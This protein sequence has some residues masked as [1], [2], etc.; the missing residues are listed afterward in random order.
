ASIHSDR[1]DDAQEEKTHCQGQ[2]EPGETTAPPTLSAH[3]GSSNYWCSVHHVSA[4]SQ[5]WPTIVVKRL[6]T[7]LQYTT[8][9]CAL[10]RW[11]TTC[12]ILPRIRL[13]K[14]STH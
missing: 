13:L 8:R 12:A 1:R 6:S 4:G 5:A 14:L 10:L 2:G 11:A 7:Q 9:R 3:G